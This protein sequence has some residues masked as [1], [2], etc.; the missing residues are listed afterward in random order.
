MILSTA[1]IHGD[2]ADH[3][4]GRRLGRQGIRCDGAVENIQAFTLLQGAR[5]GGRLLS[6]VNPDRF[7][8]KIH[9]ILAVTFRGHAELG[10]G[11]VCTLSDFL[12][13]AVIQYT[14]RQGG[15][16]LRGD[17]GRNGDCCDIG[18]HGRQGHGAGQCAGEDQ[19]CQF[20]FHSARSFF[21]LIGWN[22]V[23]WELPLFL[24]RI[25]CQKVPWNGKKFYICE[26][27]Y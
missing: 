26:V 14:V 23:R 25:R 8:R 12:H 24:R 16:L 11:T 10:D 9:H 5:V 19:Y 4:K 3:S 20:L 1:G 7:L 27:L 13:R 17:R 15:Q 22:N 21:V 6:A 18:G 2:A